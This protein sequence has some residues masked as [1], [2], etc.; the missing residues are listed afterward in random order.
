[1][2]QDNKMTSENCI[3]CGEPIAIVSTNEP[4]TKADYNK[5]KLSLPKHKIC[6][7]CENK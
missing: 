2:E 4:I 6:I 7:E 3:K 1:M 5:L